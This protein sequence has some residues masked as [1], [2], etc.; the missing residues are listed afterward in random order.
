MGS[1]SWQG[2]RFILTLNSGITFGEAQETLQDDG[3]QPQF[4]CKATFAVISPGPQRRFF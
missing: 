2:S 4:G 3:V 1:H